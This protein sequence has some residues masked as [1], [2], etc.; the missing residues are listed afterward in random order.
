MMTTTAKAV[1]TNGISPTPCYILQTYCAEAI[2][3]TLAVTNSTTH[4]HN[5]HLPCARVCRRMLSPLYPLSKA[6]WL[7]SC[8]PV[9]WLQPQP[10]LFFLDVS[11]LGGVSSAPPPRPTFQGVPVWFILCVASALPPRVSSPFPCA[12]LVEARGRAAREKCRAPHPREIPGRLG[13]AVGT[14]PARRRGR[15]RT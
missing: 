4:A 5:K 8:P 7:H 12:Y 10:C 3:D 2:L 14:S 15:S 1:G 9:G 13:R 11:D 6:T